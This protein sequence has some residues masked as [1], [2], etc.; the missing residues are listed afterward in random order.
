MLMQSDAHSS[1]RRAWRSQLRRGKKRAPARAT[2]PHTVFIAYAEIP[3]ARHAMEQMNELLRADGGN[4]HLEPMLWRFDQ[5][6]DPRWRDMALRDAGRATTL[7]LAMNKSST[8]TTSA[9]AW[10]SALVVQ[11]HGATINALVFLG[12]DG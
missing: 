6:D 5:L 4:W 10:L 1:L 11:Q 2:R 12:D 3:A 9:E 7:A 8:L